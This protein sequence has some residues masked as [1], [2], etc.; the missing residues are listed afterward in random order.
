[1]P[2][3]YGRSPDATPAFEGPL[4]M[5]LKDTDCPARILSAMRLTNVRA[6]TVGLSEGSNMGRRRSYGFSFSWK[7]AIG[8]S[9]A[10]SRISRR[11]GIPLSRSGRQR[12]VGSKVGCCVPIALFVSSLA[13]LLIL[14]YH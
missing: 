2:H 4:A 11:L 3:S 10:K 12:K 1:M 14:T 5:Y 8:L 9:G 7:R 13:L 6:A